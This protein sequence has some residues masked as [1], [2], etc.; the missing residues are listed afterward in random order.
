[1]YASYYEKP[2]VIFSAKNTALDTSGLRFAMLKDG[3]CSFNGEDRKSGSFVCPPQGG[4]C[5]LK[6]SYNDFY[7]N[8]A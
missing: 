2:M 5:P 3:T 4:S 7:T 6:G 8:Q 1:M